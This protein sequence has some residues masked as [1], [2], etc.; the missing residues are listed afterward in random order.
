MKLIPLTV[1]LCAGAMFSASAVA[2]P[3]TI[4]YDITAVGSSLTDLSAPLAIRQFDA[5]LGHLIGIELI[6]SSAVTSSVDLDNQSIHDANV[7]VSVDATLSLYRPDNSLLATHTASLYNTS[8]GIVSGQS[9]VNAASGNQLLSID[10]LLGGAGDLALFT[11]AGYLSSVLSVQ[12]V[13]A[14][15][16]P[17]GLSA[18]FNTYANG[19]GKVIYTFD[20]APVPEPATCGMLLLGLGVVAYAAQRRAGAPRL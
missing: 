1:A 10:A 4:S 2:A 18:D 6:Y 17:S 20:A 8:V 12:A 11:G 9:I 5:G 13:S 16:G 14:S 3:T 7:P 15:S 19:Y